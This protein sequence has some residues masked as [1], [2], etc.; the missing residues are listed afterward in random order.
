[1]KTSPSTRLMFC[2]VIIVLVNLS[3]CQQEQVIVDEEPL[4]RPVR[5]TIITS[6]NVAR[7]LEFPA[8]VDVVSKADLSF[9]LSG[10]LAKFY[11][12]QGDKVSKGDVLVKLDD[13][14]LK[15][16]LITTQANFDKAEADFNRAKKL[17]KT[18]FISQSEFDQLKANASATSA[19]LQTAKN[20]LAYTEIKASFNGMIAKV[21][22][23]LYQ[24]ITAKE[25]ILR[26][27]DLSKVVL[28]VNIP[29]SI[30]MHLRKDAVLGKV[31]A[32]FSALQGYEF[33]L[34]F[35]EV[36]TIADEYTKTYEVLFTMPAPK[37]FVILPGMTAKVKADIKINSPVEP[38]KAVDFYLPSNT[39]L[40]D[41]NNHYVFTIIAVK[42]GVGKV[43]KK[44][45]IIGDF[46]HKGIEVYSGLKKGDV[47]VNAGMSKITDGMLVKY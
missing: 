32:T 29:E 4:L 9:K 8:V 37:E 34:E 31:T 22:K 3:A 45:I 47:L 11:V 27:H 5:T 38:D 7:S 35:S 30:M 25:P 46:T 2:S 28:K 14:D 23:D 42:P 18:K 40:S 26:L 1:M 21:Y 19:Q 41:R 24:E 17:I 12:K 6:A 44:T 43:Q 13:T 20:N 10:E 15:L 33:P 36:S 16:S 39:V